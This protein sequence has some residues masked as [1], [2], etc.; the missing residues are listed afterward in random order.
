MTDDNESYVGVSK[1]VATSFVGPD[2]VNLLRAI[3]LK[4]ALNAYAKNKLLMTRAA[5]PTAMLKW[6]TE[7]TGKTYKRG[8]YAQ[9][10]EDV[11]VWI[12]TMRAALPVV[13]Q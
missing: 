5:T 9:A 7:Y 10:A 2:A 3:H 1:G 8:A 13:Q 12:E 4:V 6:A 11:G